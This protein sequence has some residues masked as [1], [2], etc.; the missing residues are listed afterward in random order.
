[1]GW[2]VEFN[3]VLRLGVDDVD[4]SN[5]KEGSKFK[6]KRDNVRIYIIDIPILLLKR[7]W[8]V[9]GYCVVKKSEIRGDKMILEVELVTK[10][11]KNQSDIHTN[12]FLKSL[13]RTG[14]L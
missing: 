4:A 8:T 12:C 11:N 1:M 3:T 6:V 2:H 14:Y 10:F 5:L 7:D 13:K 9:I